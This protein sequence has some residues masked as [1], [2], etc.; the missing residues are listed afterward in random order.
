M[1]S[2]VSAFLSTLPDHS[3]VVHSLSFQFGARENNSTKTPFPDE[4]Q[5]HNYKQYEIEVSFTIWS[6]FHV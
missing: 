5:C 2:L 3:V 1:I 6:S 4:F